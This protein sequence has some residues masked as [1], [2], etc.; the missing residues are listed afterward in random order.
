MLST[1]WISVLQVRG[2]SRGGTSKRNK[3]HLAA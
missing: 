1:F 3:K 2:M